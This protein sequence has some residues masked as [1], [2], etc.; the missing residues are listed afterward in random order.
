MKTVEKLNEELAKIDKEQREIYESA[1]T[2]GRSELNAEEAQKFDAYQAE[3]KEKRAEVDRVEALEKR[4]AIEKGE[5]LLGKKKQIDPEKEAKRY[6][7]AFRNYL[8]R[9]REMSSEDRQVLESRAQSTTGSA[10]GYLIP[11]GFSGEVERSM[12]QFGGMLNVARV[13]RTATGNALPWPTVDDTA[14][15]GRL[16]AEGGDSSSGTT[17]VAFGQKTLNAY[18]YTS[19]LLLASSELLQDEEIGIEPL[20]GSLLGER[21]GRIGNTHWT[22]GT[23]S[24][25]PNGVVTASTKGA[26][27]AAAAAISRVDLVNLAHGV[28]PAYRSV[29]RY[30]FND[31]TL[32]A[33]KKLSF[34]SADDRP[35]YIGG[36]ARNGSPATI[37]GYEFT[38]NQDM[39]NL[40]ANAKA[41]LFGDFS[42]YVIRMVRDIIIKR[43]DERYIE[44]DQVAFVG[45]MR[46]DGE[47]I[48]TAAVKHLLNPAS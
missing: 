9:G 39:A 35:L 41:V 38:I 34:G 32:S 46:M 1:K 33:I 48:N 36:D 23:G 7:K 45:F 31:A 5:D 26:D 29:A 19:D 40:G 22:T 16:L 17:D 25:Q 8:L 6:S 42:K 20:M 13:M 21:L 14:N 11:E 10:G 4:E 37:E 12:K 43:A 30:M 47:L 28:D 15:S 44:T 18:K 27:A 2:E 3:W 24:S